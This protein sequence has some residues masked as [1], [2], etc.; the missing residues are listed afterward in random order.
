MK[1]IIRKPVLPLLLMAALIFGMCFMCFFRQGI[2]RDLLLVEEMYQ[3][4]QLTY[5]VIPE[6]SSN[7]SLKLGTWI[8]QDIRQLEEVTDSYAYLTSPYSLKEPREAVCLSKAYGTNN[9]GTFFSEMKAGVSYAE[10]YGH[11]SLQE[12]SGDAILCVA[13]TLLVEAMG[14]KEGDSF[15][16]VPNDG[17]PA[18]NE[19]APM[20]TMK[21]IGT[22]TDT[23]GL[24]EPMGLVVAESVFFGDQGFLFNYTMKEKYG[25]YQGL[26]F[27]IDPVYNREFDRIAETVEEIIGD[28]ST[29]YSN[30]RM[31]KQAVRPMEQKLALQQA[32]AD[33]LEIVFCVA[34]GVVAMLMAL[35]FQ[36]EIFL[37]FLWG[38]SR[39]AVFVKMLFSTIIYQM[40]C[41]AAAMAAALII[42]GG[43]WFSLA[44]AYLKAALPVCLAA[45]VIPIGVNCGKNLI[46]LYQSREG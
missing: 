36:T 15:V 9:A 1:H 10:G 12:T 17:T 22:Y 6:G 5:C 11:E 18:D 28:G 3:S 46:K 39:F 14:I 4:T 24:L 27:D 31:L 41:G 44:A 8:I 45:A 2:A 33:P 25:Y 7:G 23:A 35:G 32:M 21:L 38:E 19:K 42:S 29:L 30:A 40:L 13:D 20:M 34:A 37:R 26:Q 43:E 16:I